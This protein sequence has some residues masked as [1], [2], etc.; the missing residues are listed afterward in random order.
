[1][2]VSV[3]VTLA[4]IRV[5]WKLTSITRLPSGVFSLKYD[6]PEG[7][8]EIQAKT[9]ALTVP[10]YVAADLV[11]SAA[12]S[13]GEWRAAATVVGGGSCI[14]LGLLGWLAV[15]VYP[16]SQMHGMGGE[17]LANGL[18]ASWIFAFV[19]MAAF[20]RLDSLPATCCCR[21]QPDAGDALRSFDYPPVAAVTLRCDWVRRCYTL[22]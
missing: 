3:H 2:L 5:N 18:R 15:L 10:A 11:Q 8:K 22:L 13:F 17:A 16:G 9:V 6:T 14:A 19:W 20:Q 7:A 12:V 21:L 1:M 4:G